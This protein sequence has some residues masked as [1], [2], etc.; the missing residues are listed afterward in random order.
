VVASH[1]SGLL[2]RRGVTQA[3]GTIE[4]NMQTI[5]GQLDRLLSGRPLA[6]AIAGRRGHPPG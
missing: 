6:S 5:R 3:T 1:V 4:R 2:D